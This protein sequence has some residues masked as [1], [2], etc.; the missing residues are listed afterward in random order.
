MSSCA[1]TTE[2][3]KISKKEIILKDEGY[4]Q[5]SNIKISP[6]DDYEI[7]LLVSQK[8]NQ[9]NDLLGMNVSHKSLP[10][11]SVVK[12]A[13]PDD[14]L[15]FLIAR[16]VK[17]NNNSTFSVSPE[18]VNK[19]NLKKNIYIEYLKEESINLR[20]VENSKEESKIKMDST[21]I[22]TETLE[23]E[24]TGVSSKLDYSKIENLEA[25]IEKYKNMILIGSFSDINSAKLK[26]NKIKNLGLLI[27]EID[28]EIIVFTGPFNGN[29]INLKLDFLLKNG[30]S[31]AKVYQ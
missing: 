25:K 13:N 26:T 22:S 14:L 21:I 23:E 7:E 8:F 2:D 24:Q 12:I 11:P 29:D 1:V 3:Q 15:N 17:S 5:K 9:D 18:I 28:N 19:L 16:N 10:V 20:K 4:F 6:I 30:Y 31:N 27:E